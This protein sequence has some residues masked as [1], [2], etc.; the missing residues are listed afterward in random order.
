MDHRIHHENALQAGGVN[1]AV[2]HLKHRRRQIVSLSRIIAACQTG[3]TTLIRLSP[4]VSAVI[5]NHLQFAPE[6]EI[7]TGRVAALRL[8]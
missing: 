6:I 4:L 1:R 2:I 8:M 7:A 5:E 3:R